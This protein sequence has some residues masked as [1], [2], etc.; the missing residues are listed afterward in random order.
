[1]FSSIAIALLNF[2]ECY[3]NRA[4]MFTFIKR[5]EEFIEK[6]NENLCVTQINAIG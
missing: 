4:N 6:S 1:M 3:W 5:L 2:L